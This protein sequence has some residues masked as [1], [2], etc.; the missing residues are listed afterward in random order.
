MCVCMCLCA[1][2]H[3]C[4]HKLS[5]GHNAACKHGGGT[6]TTFPM[7][8]CSLSCLTVCCFII[9]HLINIVLY[10]CLYL[11]YGVGF[12]SKYESKLV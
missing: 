5:V 11:Q 12:S 7:A 2:L 4:L 9:Q 8:L 6:Q 10:C 1:I 3:S